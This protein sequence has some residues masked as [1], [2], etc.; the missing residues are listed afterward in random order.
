MSIIRWYRN[1][2]SIINQAN[3]TSI[4]I[5]STIDVWKNPNKLIVYRQRITFRLSTYESTAANTQHSSKTMLRMR[6]ADSPSPEH[7]EHKHVRTHTYTLEN[8]HELTGVS[9]V[10][11]AESSSVRMRRYVSLR[12]E[13]SSERTISNKR[14]EIE[15]TGMF[16]EEN[17]DKFRSRVAC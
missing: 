2:H 4:L 13:R 5:I 14:R 15:R 10:P 9:L 11:G 16:C 8:D 1:P 3:R 7:H 6:W 12:S 17:V